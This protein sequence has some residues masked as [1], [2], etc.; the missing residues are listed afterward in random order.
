MA[1]RSRFQFDDGQEVLFDSITAV[2][3]S[4]SDATKINVGLGGSITDYVYTAHSA[5]AAAQALAFINLCLDTGRTGIMTVPNPAAVAVTTSTWVSI[6]PNTLNIS[7]SGGFYTA[8]VNGTGVGMIANLGLQLDD[9]AGH[10][11]GL[12]LSG[13]SG[14]NV[15]ADNFSGTLITVAATY[16][17]YWNVNGGTWTDTGLTLTA[18]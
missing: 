9:G 11:I 16:H 2:A 12:S 17:L 4:S 10:I 1:I 18:S 3:I 7:S 14:D 5:N 13:A 15:S 6:T 8:T